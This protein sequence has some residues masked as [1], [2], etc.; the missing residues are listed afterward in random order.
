MKFHEFCEIL[1]L[2]LAGLKKDYLQ[3]ARMYKAANLLQVGCLEMVACRALRY[4][5][6]L[7]RE[8]FDHTFTEEETT[9]AVILLLT[10]MERV[11]GDLPLTTLE[12]SVDDSP[13]EEEEE[14]QPQPQPTKKTKKFELKISKRNRKDS[15]SSSSSS[16]EDN[17]DGE[18]EEPPQK[19]KR[20]SA[21]RKH[22]TQVKCPF[23]RCE[24]NGSD[25]KRHLALIHV[26][27]RKEVEEE[28]IPRLAAIFKAGKG[29][30]GPSTISGKKKKLGKIKKWC[31]VPGCFFITPGIHNHIK[32]K[33]SAK[34]DSVEY[35]VHLANARPYRGLTAEVNLVINKNLGSQPNPD[36][37]P[38]PSTSRK[39][40]SSSEA[41]TE[42]S[43]EAEAP[44]P[45]SDSDERS[46]SQ[47][48]SS[49]ADDV[50]YNPKGEGGSSAKYYSATSNFNSPRHQWLCG[51]FGYLRLPDAGYKSQQ[52]RLQHVRQVA[53]LL[54]ELDAKGDDITVLSKDDGDIV[55]NN[56][57]DP[58]LQNNSKAPGTIVS[59]LTSLEKFYSY[60]TSRKY[61]PKK[62]PPL[63]QNHK[64][65]FM[66]MKTSLK[67][68][69]AT[70]DLRTQDRQVRRYL[71]E[72]DDMLT[73][74]RG[75]K[76][77]DFQAIQ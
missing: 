15:S 75:G 11:A 24:F 60:L 20:P 41:E 1:R 14:P 40:D 26:K 27:A 46:S 13:E 66:S 10:A 56:W 17:S 37:E 49:A 21:K 54:E 8:K 9:V 7:A 77:E 32:Y 65:V 35:R 55:W 12:T 30:R 53:K 23:K 6:L 71:H 76:T 50:D 72:C 39:K 45:A 4:I 51:Y 33:H 36:P 61:D 28:D 58:H 31:P 74:D 38:Q 22:H 48:D 16:S 43:A 70:V 2:T 42:R 69:R 18:G 19:K 73:A 67:G 47:A 25:I 68:W 59:Y 44:P 64:D 34:K 57:V 62:M 52:N 63:H 5:S 3:V 29:T